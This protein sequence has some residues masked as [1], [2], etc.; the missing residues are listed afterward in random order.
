[1]SDRIRSVAVFCGA[2]HGHDPRHAAAAEQLGTGLARAGLTLIYGGGGVGLM[3][4][5]AAA[6]LAAGG[7]AH[8]IVPEF[9]TR[10]ERPQAALT[11]LEVTHGMH[12]RKTRM[13]ELAD[14]FVTLPGGL[15][16]LD[17]TIEVLTWR[18]LG[19]HDK[20]IIVVDV[21]G[22]A[23]PLQALLRALTAQGF[24]PEADRGL[25]RLVPDVDAALALLAAEPR[26]EAGA[27]AARL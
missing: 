15:G 25:L 1:M 17:E 21:A 18:Q 9:L 16:T 2:R 20:P 3:G 14:A 23:Q 11:T 22:W 7:R 24:V 6:A 4:V 10:V 13:Y 27:P 12:P 5:L 8:G 19:L 26:P